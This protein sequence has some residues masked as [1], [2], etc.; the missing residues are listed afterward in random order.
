MINYRI[1]LQI[2][3]FLIALTGAL[4]L[5]SVAFS[6]YYSSNDFYPLLFSSIG[7][8]ITGFLLWYFNKDQ[9]QEI[10]I[11][12]GYLIVSLGWIVMSVVGAVPFILHGSIPVF[13][14]AFFET[15]S[16]FTTTG[17][18]ILKD[19]E[20]LPSGLLFWRSMTHWIGGMGIILL[21]IA[22]LPILGIG[23]MQLYKA[24]VAGPNKDKLH[25]RVRETAK[26][27]WGIYV[28]LTFS[29]ASLL[30]I[31]GM[32]VLD[33]VCHAFGTLASGGFSTKNASIAAYHSAYIEYVVIIFMFLAGTN[34]SLHYLALHGKLKAYWQNEEFRFY[35]L[36]T[37]AVVLGITLYLIF[38]NSLPIEQSFREAAFSIISI[39][40]STGYANTDY[41][42][43]APFFSTLFLI[44]LL[45]GAC[46][47]STSGGI[48]MIRHY[49]LFK[50]SF[51]ELKRLVHPSAVI[52]VRI[53]ERAVHP[54]TLVKVAAFVILYLVVWGLGS[55][56]MA[57]TGLEFSTAFGSVAA[58]LGNIG[59]GLGT[60]GPV[61]NYA[62]VTT[63]GKWFLSFIMLLGRLEI[64]TVFLIF[65]PSLWKR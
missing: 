5:S 65:S 24:E 44:L 36:F 62:D 40:S 37:A 21:S 57:F 7:S 53:D 42:A 61:G 34:F 4:M 18:T 16:G 2:I 59:P 54:D 11:R 27:L 6:I 64:Y 9:K 13:S 60:T 31:G 51:Y 49:L 12:E 55:V 38:H 20:T 23:G 50:N 52:P 58:C 63:F 19:I 29:Q 48:K 41:E 10:K 17:A 15:M 3:G 35:F 56:V 22:I 25:P 46:S 32:D 47:G 39:L 45:F 14:D 33:S 28:M 26:R 43:W 30:F 8:I 1:I